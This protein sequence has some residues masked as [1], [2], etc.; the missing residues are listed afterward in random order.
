MTVKPYET[1]GPA[2]QTYGYGYGVGQLWWYITGALQ[3]L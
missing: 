2:A 1:V 3:I